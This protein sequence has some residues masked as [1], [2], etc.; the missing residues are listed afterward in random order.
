[1][2]ENIKICDFKNIKTNSN[3]NNSNQKKLLNNQNIKQKNTEQNKNIQNIQYKKS[4]LLQLFPYQKDEINQKN[5]MQI[6]TLLHDYKLK[7]KLILSNN[8]NSCYIDS[9]LVS[10]FYNLDASEWLNKTFFSKPIQNKIA[11]D[12]QDIFKFIFTHLYRSEMRFYDM[13]ETKENNKEIVNNL[14]N[15]FHQLN[16]YPN[17]EWLC[18]QNEPSDFLMMINEIFD[19]QH[20]V[21]IQEKTKTQTRK[22]KERYNVFQIFTH[23]FQTQYI[24]ALDIIRDKNY[25]LINAEFLYVGVHRGELY[26][27]RQIK[28]KKHIIFPNTIKLSNGFLQLSS[29]ILHLGESLHSGHFVSY[30]QGKSNNWILIDNTSNNYQNSTYQTM[31]NK[32]KQIEQNIIGATYIKKNDKEK[33]RLANYSE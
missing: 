11:K 24:D 3:P 13:H 6:N 2:N 22:I 15:K 27:N 21:C 20:D 1:M 28:S 7:R 4:I 5:P 33:K 12:I 19:V 26:Q 8:K 9:I 10:L 14:R 32:K 18:S 29:F 25:F 16:R 23:S 31:N 30:V 17:T